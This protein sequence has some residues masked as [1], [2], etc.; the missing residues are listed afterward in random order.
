MFKDFKVVKER[1]VYIQLKDYLKKDDYERAFARGSKIPSTREL[2]ELLSVSRNTVL[3]A[4]ADLEQEGLI[5]AVKGKGNFVAKVDISNTSSVEI[6]W[7]NKLNTVTLLADELD[8]MKH[9]VRWEK[10]MIVFNSIAPDEKLFDVENFKKSF[11]YSY[12]H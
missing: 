7:K 10:G 8:L 9:G 4:Y 1:P 2:S 5:Y 11:S 6:D 12:V 3:A